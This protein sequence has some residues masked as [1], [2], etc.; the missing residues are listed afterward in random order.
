M[1]GGVANG[2]FT[3]W[4]ITPVFNYYVYDYRFDVG[5]SFG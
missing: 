2:D 3:E 5:R 1:S 4:K